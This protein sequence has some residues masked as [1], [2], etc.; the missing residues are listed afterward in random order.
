MDKIT[1]KYVVKETEFQLK[2]LKEEKLDFILIDA[3][4]LFEAEIDKRCDYIISVIARNEKKLERICNRD[5]LSIE[6][7]KKRLLIQ[8]KEEFLEE[9]SDFII[10]NNGSINEIKEKVERII[11]N[12]K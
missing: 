4:L 3:P 1:F 12:I 5:N 7:A 11:N 6:N 8:K 9:N 2:K 10:D